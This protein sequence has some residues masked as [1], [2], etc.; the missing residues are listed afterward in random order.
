MSDPLPTRGRC[1]RSLAAD[2][3]GLPPKPGEP[4]RSAAQRVRELRWQL[5]RFAELIRW[6]DDIARSV[7]DGGTQLHWAIMCMRL[8]T[9]QYDGLAGEDLY[10]LDVMHQ[11]RIDPTV[12]VRR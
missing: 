12:D 6:D 11:Q 5:E 9:C 8:E 7:I 4:S 2:R 10:W 1:M 3:G